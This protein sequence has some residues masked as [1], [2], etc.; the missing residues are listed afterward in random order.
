MFPQDPRWTPL[1][2]DRLLD[3][4]AIMVQFPAVTLLWPDDGL[5]A[6][7]I[8]TI[9]GDEFARVAQTLLTWCLEQRRERVFIVAHDGTIHSYRQYLGERGLTRDSFLGDAGWYSCRV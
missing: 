7:G 2:C 3:R 6:G 9:P 1:A 5:W 4:G 8:N